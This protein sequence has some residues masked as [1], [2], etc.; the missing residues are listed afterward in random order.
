MT[1]SSYRRRLRSFVLREGRVTK[2]QQRALAELWDQ[3]VIAPT[4]MSEFNTHFPRGLHTLEIGFGMGASLAEMAKASPSC[5]FLGI[6]VH[7]PGVASLLADLDEMGCTNVKVICDDAID[8]I[9]HLIPDA[10]L[11]RVLIFFP[12]PWPKKKHH[13]RRLVQLALV[14]RL[15]QKLKESGVLHLA[16]DWDHYAE[17]MQAVMTQAA[18]FKP[19]D[20]TLD[21]RP[22]TKFE[23]R[24][25][26]LGHSIHDLVYQRTAH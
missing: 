24:G 16:T 17:H 25:V 12:D 2:R 13:K 20:A 10:S 26:R 19:I 3:Y 22:Q 11:E 6:E 9:T 8:V 23:R 18:R 15:S 4:S 1:D 14:E 5:Q 21:P 7:K